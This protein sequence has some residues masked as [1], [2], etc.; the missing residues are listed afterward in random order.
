MP[1]ATRHSPLTTRHQL[2]RDYLSGGPS[3][4]LLTSYSCDETTSAADLSSVLAAFGNVLGTAPPSVDSLTTAAAPALPAG[5]PRTA[6]YLTHPIF[7]T[8]HSEHQASSI[9]GK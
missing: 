6:E 3:N 4:L 1:L 7:N 8:Y 9:R 5:L 2:R